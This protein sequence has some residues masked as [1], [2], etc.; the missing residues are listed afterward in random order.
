[1][2]KKLNTKKTTIYLM[3]IFFVLCALVLLTIAFKNAGTVPPN[4]FQ[5]SQSPSPSQTNESQTEQI[6]IVQ[7]E[8]LNNTPEIKHNANQGKCSTQCRST[9]QILDKN[10][11]IDDE[12]FRKL[13]SSAKSIATYLTKNDDKREYY[14]QMAL[15]TTDDEKR[16]FLT[17]VFNH[18]STQHKNEIGDRFIDSDNWHARAMGV[19]LMT[20]DGIS[21]LNTAKTLTSTLSNESNSY[22]KSTIINHL[23]QSEI[24]KGNTD[25]LN[26]LDSI[27]NNVSDNA[28]TRAQALK[29]KLQLSEQ[30]YLIIPDAVQALH[31]NE[32]ELQLAG[33]IIIG[34]ILQ[35]EDTYVKNGVYIDKK[36]IK[37]AIQNLRNMPS[38]G[39]KNKRLDNLTQ[40]ANR[41]YLRYFDR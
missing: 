8:P 32:T 41:V 14:S 27:L 26:Q 10:K 19:T 33:L 20:G 1:M 39:I 40:E 13:R 17:D 23:K 34:R 18:L 28:T 30:P 3:T 21:D 25:T 15:T 31:S 9:L 7:N 4:Q 24:L 6:H 38:Q 2:L 16:R 11:T 12:T 29:A 36:S 5:N 22:V 37:N 35:Q